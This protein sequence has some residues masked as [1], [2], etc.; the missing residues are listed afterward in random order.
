MIRLKVFSEV[1][2]SKV[3][4]LI[5]LIIPIIAIASKCDLDKTYDS[6]YYSL[7]NYFDTVNKLKSHLRKHYRKFIEEGKWNKNNPWQYISTVLTK[8]VNEFHKKTS[9]KSSVSRRGVDL[10]TYYQLEK[11]NRSLDYW[12]KNNKELKE[13][14]SDE[15]LTKFNK[16]MSFLM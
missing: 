13:M 16:A 2:M 8:R 10:S 9:G 3:S 12:E 15:K 1:K 4:V 14:K 6:N 7:D 11:V 5:C